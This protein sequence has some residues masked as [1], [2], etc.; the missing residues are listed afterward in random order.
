MFLIKLVTVDMQ[1]GY[2]TVLLSQLSYS[3]YSLESN[4]QLL[5]VCLVLDEV[6]MFLYHRTD[7]SSCTYCVP[8]Q[9]L[10]YIRLI[11]TLFD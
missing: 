2:R 5:F 7:S 1:S 6:K 11:F 9:S 3:Y 10:D 4:K 8:D